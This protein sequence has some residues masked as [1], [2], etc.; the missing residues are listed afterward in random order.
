MSYEDHE[1]ARAK[2][3]TKDNAKATTGTGKRGRKPKNAVPEAEEAT[4]D[5]EQRGQKRKNHESEGEVATAKKP[6]NPAPEA[7]PS[8]PRRTPV[9]R[10]SEASEPARA[11]VARMI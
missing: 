5:M 2:R 8:E 3:A 7:G 1:A 6:K 9:V 11:P 10:M 4:T